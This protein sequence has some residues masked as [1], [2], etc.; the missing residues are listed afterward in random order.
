MQSLMAGQICSELVDLVSL[1][2]RVISGEEIE[3]T[4]SIEVNGVDVL[5]IFS[6]LKEFILT[7]EGSKEDISIILRS[8]I[9]PDLAITLPTPVYVNLG[10]PVILEDLC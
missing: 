4:E 6:G 3:I 10:K 1:A 9:I 2:E 7:I 5:I 8:S